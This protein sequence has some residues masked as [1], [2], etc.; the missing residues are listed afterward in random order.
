MLFDHIAPAPYLSSGL[1]MSP[2]LLVPAAALC[3]VIGLVHSWLGERRLIGPLL[4]AREGLLQRRFARNVLRFAWHLTTIAWI[5]IGAALVA[6]AGVAADIGS[7]RAVL[8]IAATMLVTGVVILATGRGR[9]WAWPVFF[10]IAV[11]A[12]AA[13]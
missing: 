9:H 8:A 13:A 1:H 12:Y 3:V 7:S 2:A 5:G 4:A 11:L 6:F 10:A